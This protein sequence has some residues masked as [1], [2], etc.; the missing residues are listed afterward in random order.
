ME[1]K[2]Q[3]RLYLA[4]SKGAI[5]KQLAYKANI[6]MGVIGRLIMV[7][8]T[9][10]L[11]KAIYSSSD[12]GIIKGFSLEEMLVYIMMT[13]MIS[14]VTMC[15]ISYEIGSE[16]RDGSIAMNL[17]KPINFRR[18]LVFKGLGEF[19]FSFICLFLP[20][21]LGISIY[22][23]RMLGN[24]NISRLILFTLSMFLGFMIN[25]YY[26]YLFG[27]LAFKFYGLWGIS[28]IATAIINLISGALIP[29]TF[30]PSM[31]EKIFTLLPFSSIVYTPAMIYLGKIPMAEILKAIVIQGIWV[32]IFFLFSKFAWGKV[33]DKL[34]IQGG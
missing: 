17:I 20:A 26:S 22:S 15:S 13:F 11:W 23:E 3:L 31:I 4:F 8:V 10:F 34:T 30:F 24:L 19:A 12:E 5:K 27:L 21:V 33:V 29:L 14:I 7:T 1:L 9:F 25:L 2:R 32:F 16:V 18:M 6:I 28:Q